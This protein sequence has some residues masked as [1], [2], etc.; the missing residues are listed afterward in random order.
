MDLVRDPV[1]RLM[2]QI[3]VPFALG[4]I[5]NTMFNVTDTFF[6]GRLSTDA[7]AALSLSFPMFFLVFGPGLGIQT[8]ASALISNALGAGDEERAVDYQVQAI[9]LGLIVTVIVSVGLN[10]F[11]RPLYLFFGADG[12]VLAGGLRY[13]RVIATGGVVIILAQVLNAGLVARGDTKAFRNVLIAMAVLNVGLDPLLMF[14]LSVG[15]LQIV[16]E[17]REAGTAIATIALQGVGLVYLVVRGLRQGVY[18]GATLRRCRPRAGVMRELIGQST[19]A[20]LDFLILTLGSFVINYFVADFGRDPIAAYG[21]ALRI[22]QI[23]LLPLFGISTALASLVGQNN[24]ARRLDRVDE[25]FRVAIRYSIVAAV[26]ILTPVLLGAA[27][28]L[29]LFSSTGEVVA[30]GRRYLYIQGLTYFS[31]ILLNHSNAVLRGLKRPMAIMWAGLYRQAAAPFVVFPLLAYT[32][33]LG[34]DGV[35]WGLVVVNWSAA[36]FSFWWSRRI[37]ARERSREASRPAEVAAAYSSSR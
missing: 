4:M 15:D 28:L 21:A 6:A 23:A 31:Y 33:A 3:S 5:F 18:R 19:P 34:V 9:V 11:L 17:L 27:P 24:G 36:V 10:V 25:S 14:G 29:R 30:I 13:M 8:G 32:A 12:E 2:R 16:P 7:L 26:A 37:L 1:P 20:T 35:F 22:E